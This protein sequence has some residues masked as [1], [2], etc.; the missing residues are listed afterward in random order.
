[1]VVIVFGPSRARRPNGGCAAPNAMNT[2]P[3]DDAWIGILRP[4][5]LPAPSGWLLSTCARRATPAGRRDADVRRLA[6]R[7]RRAA[8]G[9]AARAWRDRRRSQS[10]RAYST[11]TGPGPEAAAAPSLREPVP[12]ERSQEPRGRRLRQLRLLHDAGERHDLVALD[13]PHENAR[14]AV[15]RLGFPLRPWSLVPHHGTKL[16]AQSQ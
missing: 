3:I 7:S 6:R 12:L 9:T 1:M 11:S 4:T 10:R 2:F 13:Q 15:D 8:R 5:Q 14:G 16:D